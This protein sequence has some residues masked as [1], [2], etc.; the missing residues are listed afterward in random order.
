MDLALLNDEE[1]RELTGETNLAKAAEGVLTLGP[2]Y[3]AIKRGEHGASLTSAAGHF[4]L[5]CFPVTDVCDPTGAGDS[6]AG[7]LIGFLAAQDRADEPTLRQALACGTV[8]ASACVQGFSLGGLIS[9][10][11]EGLQERYHNLRCA[12]EFRPLAQNE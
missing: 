10:T 1:A 6:F 4:S 7:G 5:P 11:S 9:L 2:K 12:T 8:L 3:V